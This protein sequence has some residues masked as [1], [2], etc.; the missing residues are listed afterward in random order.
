M[1]FVPDSKRNEISGQCRKNSNLVGVEIELNFAEHIE[2]EIKQLIV[3]ASK[4]KN[5]CFR[6]L[7]YTTILQISFLYTA[8][9]AVLSVC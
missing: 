8:H 3:K 6:I 1:V 9:N 4:L 5:P 2:T 7:F